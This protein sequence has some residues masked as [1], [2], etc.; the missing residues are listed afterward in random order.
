MEQQRKTYQEK[1]HKSLDDLF[2]NIDSL[3]VKLRDAGKDFSEGM[4]KNIAEMK[5]E[6]EKL[7][8]KFREMCDSNS[9]SWSEVRNGFEQAA[10]SLR[11]A[12]SKAW[13]NMQEKK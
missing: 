8:G 13:K 9:D 4:E 11:D 6:G 5:V 1:A 3:E 2:S 10:T 7:K 12:F